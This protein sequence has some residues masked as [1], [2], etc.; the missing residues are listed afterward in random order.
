MKRKHGVTQV[1]VYV[2]ESNI[3]ACKL[4]TKLGFVKSGTQV[5]KRSKIFDVWVKD[6]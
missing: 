2:W 1:S 6:V 3:Q 5:K 4:Y